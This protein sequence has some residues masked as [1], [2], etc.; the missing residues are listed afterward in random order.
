[1]ELQ[2]TYIYSTERETNFIFYNEKECV[3]YVFKLYIGIGIECNIHMI[4]PFLIL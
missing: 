2:V 3:W 4:Q 1:M